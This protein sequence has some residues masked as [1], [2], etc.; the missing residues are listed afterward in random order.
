[1]VAFG[2]NVIEIIIKAKDEFSRILDKANVSV[3]DFSRAAKRAGV[4]ITG[5]GV[6]GAAAIA[7]IISQAGKFEQTKTAFTTFLGSEEAAMAKLK[8]LTDFATRTPFTVPGVE[9]SARQLLAVGFEA[10]DLIP[11]LKSVGDVASGLGLGEEG[12]QRLILNLGQVKT[13]GRLTGREL[14]DFAVAGV[15][16]IQELAKNFGKTEAQIR[17]M[18]SAGRI[19]FKDVIK[20]FETMSGEGG[21]F[22]NLMEKQSKTFLGQVSNITDSLIKLAR[23]MGDVLL[24]VAKFVADILQKII[25]FL[26]QHPTIAKVVAVVLAL[27][28]AF[29]LI[30]GPILLLVGFLPGIVA[31]FSMLIPVIGAITAVSLPWL[32]ILLGIIAAVTGIILVI[33]NWGKI[34][35]FINAKIKQAGDAIKE[36]FNKIKD[37]V[38]SMVDALKNAIKVV[39]KFLGFTSGIGL[40]VK[41]VRSLTGLGRTKKVGDAI[42]RPN[43]QI[44]ET[45]PRDTLIAT[46]GGFGGIVINI[47]GGTFSSESFVEEIDKALSERIGTKLSI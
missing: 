19:G 38:M 16:L 2:Q 45:D 29:A 18:V 36:K 20:A 11:V 41:A 5:F 28:S 6:A 1:M 42:I 25:S 13:Q 17:E 34:T 35:D 32:G 24:P 4:A 43:G 10:K 33:K 30:V 31:G 15:P 7:G 46:K 8:E 9:R 12:L 3:K 21:Q 37:A 14:R 47:N 39:I 27:A 40:A 44:I 26:E 23:I 22:F